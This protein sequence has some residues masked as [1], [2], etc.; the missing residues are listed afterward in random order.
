M[1]KKLLNHYRGKVVQNNDPKK[2]GRVKVFIPDLHMS[3]LEIDD[4]DFENEFYFAEWGTNLQADE[5]K[6]DL[7]KY[8]DRLKMKL[9]WAEVS[10]PPIGGGNASYNSASKLGTVSDSNPS[11]F[12]DGLREGDDEPVPIGYDYQQN[13]PTDQISGDNFQEANTFSNSYFSNN[14]YNAPKGMFGI[15][16]V[17]TNVWVFF[18]DG[19]PNDPVVFG[20]CPSPGAYDQVYDDTSY[21]NF[22]ENRASGSTSAGTQQSRQLTNQGENDAENQIRRD[23]VVW[24]MRGGSF[25]GEETDNWL[26]ISMNHDY[27]HMIQMNPSGLNELIVGQRSSLIKGDTQNTVEGSRFKFVKENDEQTVQGDYVIRLG[28]QNVEAAQKWKDEAQKIHNVKSLSEKQDR[29]KSFFSSP[30]QTKAGSNPPCPACSQGKKR[31]TIRDGIFSKKNIQSI[32][33]EILQYLIRFILFLLG[34]VLQ[35]FGINIE[36]PKPKK[37]AWPPTAD[38][39]VCKGTGISPSSMDGNFP[40]EPRKKQI[41]K[42]YEKAAP[43]LAEYENEM[44]GDNGSMGNFKLYAGGHVYIRSGLVDNNFDAIRVNEEGQGNVRKV[45]LDKKNGLYAAEEAT[46]SVEYNHVD[47]FPGGDITFDAAQSFTASSGAGG[48]SIS[49][50][51]ATTVYGAINNQ[52]G[53]QVNIGA[54]TTVSIGGESSVDIRSQ[55][56]ISINSPETYLKNKVSVDGQ[57]NCLGGAM[58]QGDVKLQSITAPMAMN[59]TEVHPELHGTTHKYQQKKIGFIK[60]GQGAKVVIAGIGATTIKF[61]QS[62]PV[63]SIDHY[64]AEKPDEGSIYAYPHFHMNRGPQMKLTGSYEEFRE[65]AAKA[66]EAIESGEQEY[67]LAQPAKMAKLGPPKS[68]KDNL[69]PEQS[70]GLQNQLRLADGKCGFSTIKNM[71]GMDQQTSIQDVANRIKGL[72]A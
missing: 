18:I 36:L 32:L 49:S 15:P 63:F 57:L 30:L 55:K 4:D 28:T 53:E 71:E 58:F 60:R 1:S 31:D 12:P 29:K 52:L 62:V 66:Q 17:G 3:L 47:R 34:I 61:L 21:P 14:L 19:N 7:T 39:K 70:M 33:Q 69:V 68:I 26:T 22:Y 41:A 50:L 9:P 43:K 64:N 16:Q 2:I 8:I 51:G 25:K 24:N 11:H 13:P 59:P 44:A 23:Q 20:Y 35:N 56:G 40:D 6:I 45:K 5:K 10:L 48:T 72:I 38:C 54:K 42:L 67:D 37:D 65:E 27:G 46:P